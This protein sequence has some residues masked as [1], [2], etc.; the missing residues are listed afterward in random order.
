MEEFG[1][2]IWIRFEKVYEHFEVL[3][4]ARQ[5]AVVACYDYGLLK[6]SLWVDLRI[7]I[8]S[9]LALLHHLIVCCPPGS[10]S[11]PLILARL[12]IIDSVQILQLV[13]S[14]LILV[15]FAPSPLFIY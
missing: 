13:A 11:T 5:V 12:T 1:R 9:Q 7:Q 10:I 4:H 2:C 14:L 15:Y 8:A 3:S 6:F